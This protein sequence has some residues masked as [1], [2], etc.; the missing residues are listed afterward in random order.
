MSSVKWSDSEKRV[1]RR[2]FEAAL[3]GELAEVMAEFKRRAAT[4]KEPEDMWSVEQYL[5]TARRDIDSKYDYR[6]SQLDLVFGRLLREGRIEEGHL[7][8]LSEEKLAYIR[9]VASL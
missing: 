6:Y 8:G 7:H 2:V 1:A 3:Q 5:A 4:A 9:R